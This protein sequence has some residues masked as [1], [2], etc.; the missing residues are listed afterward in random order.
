MPR[1][2]ILQNDRRRRVLGGVQRSTALLSMRRLAAT[3][4]RGGCSG[5][6]ILS[7]RRQRAGCTARFYHVELSLALEG[8][9]HIYLRFHRPPDELLQTVFFAVSDRVSV[10]HNAELHSVCLEYPRAG[11]R[12]TYQHAH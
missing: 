3:N 9:S 4:D 7:Q 1:A 8:Q 6:R 11:H 12:V 10:I 5:W 2:H